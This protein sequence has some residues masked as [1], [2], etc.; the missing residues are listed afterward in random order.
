MYDVSFVLKYVCFSWINDLDTVCE[1]N[2][3]EPCFRIHLVSLI[4]Y[5]IVYLALYL[6]KLLPPH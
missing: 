5:L 2:N 4:R 6:Q 3:G 1:G